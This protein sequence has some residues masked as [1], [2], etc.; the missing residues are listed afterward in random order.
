MGQAREELRHDT[1]PGDGRRSGHASGEIGLQLGGM[2]EEQSEQPQRHR[3]ARV[4]GVLLLTQP[5]VREESTG[6]SPQRREQPAAHLAP[7]HTETRGRFCA[8][9]RVPALREGVVK[10]VQQLAFGTHDGVIGRLYLARLV[11]HGQAGVAAEE[12]C[13]RL[14]RL[15]RRGEVRRE[16][17]GDQLI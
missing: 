11:V 12:E 7:Q 14:A 4:R 15:A 17:L 9:G 16:P 6:C 2:L 5:H 1:A 3:D 13:E 8:L 10:A